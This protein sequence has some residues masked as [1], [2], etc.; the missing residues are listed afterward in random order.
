MMAAAVVSLSSCDFIEG[1]LFELGIGDGANREDDPYED[2]DSMSTAY[3]LW[4]QWDESEWLSNHMGWAEQ[5][6]D[7]WYRIFADQGGLYVEAWFSHEN[8]N[9]DIELYDQNGNFLSGSYGTSDGEVIDMT[10][11]PNQDYFILVYG[12]G[13]GNYDLLWYDY[14][15]DDTYEE[16]D[17]WFEAYDLRAWE[18]AWLSVVN[19]PANQSDADN[20][21]I[22]LN[23][24]SPTT[25]QLNFVHGQGDLALQLL[26]SAGVPVAASNG[27][28]DS[29]FINFAPPFA[30]DYYIEV[31]GP[32]LGNSYDLI[33]DQP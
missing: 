3:D 28:G 7:D 14:S 6:D 25:I 20:Y 22:S 30:D 17:T 13:L 19:G 18:N 4:G 9:V 31:T 24:S 5:I 8:G 10:V 23:A 12:D 16:N 2:N 32:N 11:T 21:W 33:W 29:E 27:S 1:I 26:D 15:V